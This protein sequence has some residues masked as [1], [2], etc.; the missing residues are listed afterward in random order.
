MFDYLLHF[1]E[2]EKESPFCKNKTCGDICE[3]TPFGVKYCTIDKKCILTPVLPDCA[4][5]DLNFKKL[6]GKRICYTSLIVDIIL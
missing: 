3:M 4:G 1:T 5:I 6:K 2:S